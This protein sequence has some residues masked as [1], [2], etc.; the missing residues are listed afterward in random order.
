[1]P[2]R[3]APHPGRMIREKILQP[4]GWNVTSGAKIPGV[5]RQA[6][7]NLVNQRACISP[8][9]AIRLAKAFRVSTQTWLRMR[10]NYDLVGAS[11]A[12]QNPRA[13]LSPW[14]SCGLKTILAANLYLSRD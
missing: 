12:G 7:N 3:N 5:S 10:S 6:L 14:T 9:M 2:M 11:V 4:L 8:A 1:M 13:P